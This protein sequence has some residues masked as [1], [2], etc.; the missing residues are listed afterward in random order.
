MIVD[1]QIKM[2]HFVLYKKTITWEKI[3]RLFLDNI[4]KYH[5]L[6]DDI[7]PNQE[8]QF[9]FKILKIVFLNFE[10]GHE[11]FLLFILRIMA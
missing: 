11:G 2:M 3:I 7:R 4:Y 8:H 5:E 6:R 9:V 10:G 1:L